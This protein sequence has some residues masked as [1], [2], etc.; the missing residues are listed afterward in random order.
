M[1]ARRPARPSTLAHAEGAEDVITAHLDPAALLAAEAYVCLAAVL[2]LPCLGPLHLF[3]AALTL[4]RCRFDRHYA[5]ESFESDVD[6]DSD[7]EEDEDGVYSDE[8]EEDGED[9]GDAADAADAADV[10]D[11]ASHSGARYSAIDGH[12]GSDAE[13]VGESVESTAPASRSSSANAH[14]TRGVHSAHSGST[15][16]QDVSEEAHLRQSPFSRTPDLLLQA[17]SDALANGCEPLEGGGGGWTGPGQECGWSCRP[18]QFVHTLLLDVL[19]AD[20]TKRR[21]TAMLLRAAEQCR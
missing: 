15:P 9:E 7:G 6:E 3:E 13:T 8:D 20:A 16:A 1:V 14:S 4:G 19:T 21:A 2:R 11:P 17:I 18:C 12:A 10:T 5:D